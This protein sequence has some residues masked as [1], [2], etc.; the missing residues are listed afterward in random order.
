MVR[1]LVVLEEA[2]VPCSV[3]EHDGEDDHAAPQCS[4]Y[5]PA[6]RARIGACCSIVHWCS[7]ELR[8]QAVGN[9]RASFE[10]RISIIHG[11]PRFLAGSN[12]L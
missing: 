4:K 9:A 2:S 10:G 11:L 5:D 8:V 3:R 6:A 7:D 1:T 12:G